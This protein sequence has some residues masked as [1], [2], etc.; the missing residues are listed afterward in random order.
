MTSEENARATQLRRQ[1]PLDGALAAAIVEA[2][3]MIVVLL[4]L[5]GRIDYANPFFEAL[6]GQPLAEFA[7]QDWFTTFLPARDH[8]RARTCF[9]Q[10]CRGE[11]LLDPIH[12]IVTASGEEREIEWH[13][14]YRRAV[15][16][17]PTR[18]VC[19]GKDV[20]E[21]R[22]S[23]RARHGLEQRIAS[24]FD[25]SFD[26]Q[27]VFSVEPDGEL[28]T[29]AVNCQV[30]ADLRNRG[31]AID[32]PAAIGRTRRELLSMQGVP[33]SIIADGDARIHQAI[34]SGQP[35]RFE[36]CRVD[37][38]E[39]VEVEL[40]I[41]PL[42]DEHGAC[43]HV[44]LS[45]RNITDRIVAARAL[46]SSEATLRE[47]QRLGKFGSWE[48]DV[49]SGTLHW[50]DEIFR[51]FELDPA[52]FG[53]SYAAFLVAVHPE[54]RALVDDA[55]QRSLVT[56]SPY[57]IVHRL[58]MADGRVKHVQEIGLTVY[59]EHGTPL[60]TTGTIQDITERVHAELRLKRILAAMLPFVGLFDL[61]GRVLE[62][63]REPVDE[64]GQP[65]AD[66][67]TLHCWELSYFRH[68]PELQDRIREAIAQAAAGGV[69]QDDY[70]IHIHGQAPAIYE[71]RF[72]P[73]LDPG[74]RV[75]GVICSGIDVTAR[76]RIE[77]DLRIHSQLLMSMR[78]GVTFLDA[79]ARIR[80]TNPAIER[81]FGY[82]PGELLGQDVTVLNDWSPAE[83]L[84]KT[85][86][87]MAQLREHGVFEGEFRNRRRDGSVFYCHAVIT[88]LKRP[89][90]TLWFS[91]QEDITERRAVEHEVRR[92]RDLLRQVI[93]ASPDWIY[94]KDLAQRFLLV[95]EA[96]A[97]AHDLAPEA[98]V[99]RPDSDF[100]PA[101]QLV[102]D[103]SRGIRGF[104]EDDDRAMAGT[105][106][107]NPEVAAPLAGAG[108]HLF[109]TFKAPLHDQEGHA[110]GMLGH[111]RDVTR[112]VEATKSLR[113][114]L[115]EKETLLR[116]I[117]HRVKNNLQIISSLLH[118]QART[119]KNP[120]D[121]AA[122]VE[123]RRRLLAM[124]LVHE[125]LYQT[126]DLSQIEFHGYIRALVRALM[127]SHDQGHVVIDTVADEIHLP[128]ELALPSGMILCEL[129]T[130]I[131]K[132]A[133]RG[134]DTCHALVSARCDGGR[135][136]L[137]VDDD[138]VGFPAGFDPAT[139]STF[140]WS[141]I[142]DLVLQL[143][144]TLVTR[145]AHGAHVEITFTRPVAAGTQE[146]PT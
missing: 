125:R 137:T 57:E 104:R 143:D 17:G 50:S 140:G 89:G 135:V 47:A 39:R 119:V 85:Q 68:S 49:P 124:L 61:D 21:A 27:A 30:L 141:L 116:E 28:R 139:V 7:G 73:L 4:D 123:G 127:R 95:N 38:D 84:V 71:L 65:L 120:E 66:P 134:R 113:R 48:L 22:R 129:I 75:E 10:V 13:D 146:P 52:S 144:G 138:G 121:V 53:A 5:E 42:L 37:G 31:V 105:P 24:T 12:T 142:R 76:R 80:F 45:A 70:P 51:I 79:A 87:V 107:R 67:R 118:F 23:A 11:P 126:K 60:R 106:I 97:A 81:M 63:N 20:T 131:F 16:D 64:A 43:T 117:H 35:L 59:D 90:E 55:F 88:A 122:F 34:A 114:S 1:K 86:E 2:A 14:P 8:E 98:M 112:R 32:A 99:G 62:L 96:F 145:T 92:T 15:G 46:R 25:N 54:D 132:Y 130:N 133:A 78:E 40:A 91:I 58:Q 33:A 6:V 108:R 128:I 56:R 77:D 103:P 9:G 101:E 29:I 18:L 72:N 136:I 94:A 109:D 69:V 19:I 82:G 44:H 41:T 36:E 111:W 115:A 83:N 93:D 26:P 3:P 102:G 100:F 74:G 110:Y